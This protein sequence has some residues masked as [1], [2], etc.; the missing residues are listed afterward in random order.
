M[1][2][3]ALENPLADLP[4]DVAGMTARYLALVDTDLPGRVESLYLVGSIALGDYRPGRSDV[5]F[6]AVVQKGLSEDEITAL[7][8][9]HSALQSDHPMTPFD[10]FYMTWPDLAHN[11]EEIEAAPSILHGKFDRSPS[12]EANPST[13]VTL[14]NH[15]LAVRGPA[16]PRVWHDAG[17]VRRWNAGNL[18]SYWRGLAEQARNATMPVTDGIMDQVVGWCV[19]GVTRLHYTIMTGDTTSKAGASR[20]ALD[21][22]PVRWHAVLEEAQALRDGRHPVPRPVEERRRDVVEFMD[23]VI[24]DGLRHQ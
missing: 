9:V 16:V 24:A 18:S 10:G 5:D 4:S 14:R 1:E 20:Y 3:F 22:F 21:T 19:P 13:W 6:I 8:H 17:V 11:P 23:H 12:F 15:P 2:D 7:E